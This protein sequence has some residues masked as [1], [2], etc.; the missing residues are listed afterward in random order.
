M[1]PVVKKNLELL[2][3]ASYKEGSMRRELIL[4]GVYANDFNKGNADSWRGRPCIKVD[5][6]YDAKT[7]D[8]N[9]L[10]SYQ[11]LSSEKS[12]CGTLI[13]AIDVLRTWKLRIIKTLLETCADTA[14]NNIKET[15]MLY[16]KMHGFKGDTEDKKDYLWNF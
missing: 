8:V 13:V 7:G 15:A 3:S 16:N 4:Q 10:G 14:E 12:E 11:D 5:F 1:N 6:C 9:C 2:T